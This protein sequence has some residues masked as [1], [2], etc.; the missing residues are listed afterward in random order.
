MMESSLKNY[1]VFAIGSF[2][3]LKQH[4]FERAG[5][6]ITVAGKL[7]LKEKLS[8]TSMEISFNTLAAEKSVPFIH[9]HRQHEEAYLFLAGNGEFQVDGETFPIQQGT[10]VRVAPAGERVLR[11]TGKTELIFIVI[12]AVDGS[13]QGNDIEDGEAVKTAVRWQD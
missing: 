2:E 3:Q 8:L 4:T 5:A 7:F 12:Q 9:R 10:A 13:M 1:S 11:N 6:P